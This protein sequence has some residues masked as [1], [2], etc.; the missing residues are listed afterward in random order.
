[1]NCILICL[2]NLYVETGIGYIA[3]QPQIPAWAVEMYG[4]QVERVYDPN[5][6]ANPMGR[7][8]IG[9]EWQPGRK[10]RISFELRHESWI[11]TNADHG[12]NSAWASVRVNPFR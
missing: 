8:A 2:A 6:T 12:Q 10:V 5:K 7:L 11:G 3:K 4:P 1:M 9:H